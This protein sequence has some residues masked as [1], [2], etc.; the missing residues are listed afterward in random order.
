VAVCA[1]R[2]CACRGVYVYVYVYV[3]VC[4][5]H[6]VVVCMYV[7]LHHCGE[8]PRDTALHPVRNPWQTAWKWCRPW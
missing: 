8:H 6:G 1:R 3:H 2:V 5:R 7:Q 4:V